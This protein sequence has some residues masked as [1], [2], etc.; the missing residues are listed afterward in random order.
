[1]RMPHF[2]AGANSPPDFHHFHLRLHLAIACF[3]IFSR[4][5]SSGQAQKTDCHDMVK[6]KPEIALHSNFIQKEKSSC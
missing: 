2:P 3:A 4:H 1:L 6:T 5:F